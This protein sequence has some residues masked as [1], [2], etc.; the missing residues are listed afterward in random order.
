MRGTSIQ[1]PVPKHRKLAS[2]YC[3]YCESC[4]GQLLEC[5]L[6]GQNYLSS[7][8]EDSVQV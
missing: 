6:K 8:L 7:S 2:V 3:E 4:L 5:G 1:I